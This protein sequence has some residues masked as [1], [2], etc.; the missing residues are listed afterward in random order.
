MITCNKFLIMYTLELA[1]KKVVYVT[2]LATVVPWNK[3]KSMGFGLD[4][5][6]IWYKDT[7]NPKLEKN[8]SSRF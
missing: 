3:K 6:F 8:L 1:K 7:L 4:S 2:H 5:F